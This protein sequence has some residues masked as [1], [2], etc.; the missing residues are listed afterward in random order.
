MTDVARRQRCFTLK[1]HK[2]CCLL[3]AFTCAHG[4]CWHPSALDS[5]SKFESLNRA[6]TQALRSDQHL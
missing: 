4:P 3:G 6:T 1:R 5:R 2:L